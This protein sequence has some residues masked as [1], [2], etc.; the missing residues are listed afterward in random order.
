MRRLVYRGLIK[1]NKKLRHILFTTQEL[2]R[3]L[4]Q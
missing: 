2:D 3:F 1:P 4:D